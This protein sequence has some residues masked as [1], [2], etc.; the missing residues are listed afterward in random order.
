[1]S[2]VRGKKHIILKLFAHVVALCSCPSRFCLLPERWLTPTDCNVLVGPVFLVTGMYFTKG[3]AG[4]TG[5]QADSALLAPR[6]VGRS[7]WPSWN[8]SGWPATERWSLTFGRWQTGKGNWRPQHG[9]GWVQMVR[10]QQVY[11][12]TLPRQQQLLLASQ[13]MGEG[14]TRNKEAEW[15]CKSFLGE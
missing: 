11:S 3:L 14:E 2:T 12:V 5:I 6:W 8:F 10:E 7:R 15:F 4:K 13:R 1:M 9:P